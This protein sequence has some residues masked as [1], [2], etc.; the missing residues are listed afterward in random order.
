MGTMMYSYSYTLSRRA[1]VVTMDLSA[2]N[3]HMLKTDH[4]L[5]SEANVWQLWLDRP[6]WIHADN[7]PVP[8]AMTAQQRMS[9]WK[10][11]TL[12]SY[13]EQ[14]DAEGLAAL[15]KSSFS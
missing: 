3:L 5:S 11:N 13:L 6:A 12:A 7:I 4:W 8:P 2:L 1:V 9:S 14:E 10:V 15:A